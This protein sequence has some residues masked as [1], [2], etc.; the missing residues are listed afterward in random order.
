MNDRRAE[1]AAKF[2][3]AFEDMPQLETPAARPWVGHAWHLYALRLNLDRLRINRARFVEELKTRQ[4]GTSVHFIPL[5]IHPYYRNTCGYSA[6][7]FPV[8]YGEYQREVSL[9][10]YSAM[11]DQDVNDVIEA[12]TDVVQINAI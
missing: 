8:A 5:H 7:D 9:P 10:I 12:V 1:I 6:A 3:A 4:I 2:D 11:S